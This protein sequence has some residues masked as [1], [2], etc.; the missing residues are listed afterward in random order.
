M[1][2]KPAKK[3]APVKKPGRPSKFTQQVAGAVCARVA[4]GESLRRICEDKAMPTKTMVMRWLADPE[5]AE[6]RDQYAC[7]R[8]A[9]ADKLVEDLL[10]IADEECT[11]VKASKHGSGD[12][13]G[14]GRTEVIFDAVAV[15]RNKLRVDTRKWIAARM[16]PKKYGDKVTQE[17][18]GAGGGPVDHS[19]K[20]SFE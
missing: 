19:I 11:M 10:D 16:A 9:Q 2:T 14:E 6:F 12:D 5:R 4:D 17:I 13:D 15:A 18:T 1:A 3:A 20:V 8:E 7:A